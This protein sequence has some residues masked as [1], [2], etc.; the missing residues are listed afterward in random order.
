[1]IPGTYNWQVQAACSTTPP[2]DVTP[3]STRNSFTVGS[4]SICPA[5][6]TDIDGNVYNTVQIGDQCWMAENLKVQRYRNGVVIP[7]NLS[8]WTSLT[9]GAYVVYDNILAN[10]DIYGLL[11]NWFATVDP[12]G[13][14]PLGWHV[15]SDAEWTQMITVLDPSTCGSCIGISHSSTAG[16]KMKTTGTLFDGTGLWESPNVGANNTSGFSGLPGGVR[17]GGVSMSP[18]YNSQGRRSLWWSTTAPTFSVYS[19]WVRIL[20]YDYSGST[21][22]AVEKQAGLSVRCIKD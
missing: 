4:V 22:D 1:M 17:I 10:K 16:G 7:T 3:I 13:L 21:R 18:L 15:P 12:Q 5:T 14:C 9:F 19:A 2:Y 8:N 6:V 20:W 11:Y